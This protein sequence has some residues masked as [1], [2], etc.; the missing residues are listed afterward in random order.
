MV[1][2]FWLGPIRFK[3]EYHQS[4][5]VKATF[6]SVNIHGIAG[7]IMTIFINHQTMQSENAL[8]KNCNSQKVHANHQHEISAHIFL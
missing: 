2:S 8:I 4:L 6:L 3:V 7:L 1:R 5:P